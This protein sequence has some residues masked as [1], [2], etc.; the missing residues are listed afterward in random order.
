MWQLPAV[1][2]LLLLVGLPGLALRAAPRA[3]ASSTRLWALAPPKKRQVAQLPNLAQ[4]RFPIPPENGYDVIVIGS[5]PGGEACAVRAAQL[6][7]RVAI[8]EKKQAFGGPTGLTSKA[9]REATKRICRAVD[10]I[11][12]D[13]RRQVRGLWRRTFPALKTEAEVFQV[14]ETRTRLAKFGVD[15]FVGDASFVASPS[16]PTVLRVCRKEEECVD[17]EASHVVVATGSRPSKPATVYPSDPSSATLPYQSSRIVTAT[18]MGSLKELPNAIAIV[19]GGVI[20]V[21][22]ATVLAE[23]GVGVSLLCPED[24]FMAI[25]DKDLK[26]SLKKKMKAS[27]VLFVHER[28]KEIKVGENDTSDP[29]KVVL[30]P[31]VF[32]RH[33]ATATSPSTSRTLP[34]RRLTVDL[35]MYSGGRDAN[36]DGL[37]LAHVGVQTGRYGRIVVDGSCRCTLEDG[38]NHSIFAIGDCN[39]SG[40]ASV[41]QHQG[42]AVSELLFAQ[43]KLKLKDDAKSSGNDEQMDESVDIETDSFFLVDA[44]DGD[45]DKAATLFGGATGD[46]PLTLW[47][48]PEMASTGLTGEQ[49]ASL[50]GAD[51]IV[52]G[53]GYFKDMAR[54]RLTDMDGYLKVVARKA[55]AKGGKHTILGVQILGDG[56]NELIQLGSILVHTKATLEQ[57]SHTPFAAVTLAALLQM[58]CDDALLKLAPR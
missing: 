56:A 34:E 48:I 29:L 52:L 26:E 9:V 47:T 20:A 25:L 8:V 42:R 57:V 17:L 44:E 39:G 22:Y 6:G 45:G 16:F 1:W 54:G 5:G 13:R 50:Y 32:L 2:L 7:K 37:G 53:Y 10:Q 51:N 23:L 28:I 31:R 4:V 11:G 27:H 38:K 18:E 49:A 36:S 3:R 12:G 58:A 19:G 21:E 46:S 43:P 41:A 30:E 15:L 55:K 35:V 14:V 24:G 33:N 40:L